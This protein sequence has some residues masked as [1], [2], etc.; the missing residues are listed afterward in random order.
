MGFEYE[1]Y[2]RKGTLPHIWCPGCGHGIVMKSLLRAIDGLKLDKNDIAVVSGIGCASRLPGYLDMNTLHTTHGRALAFATGIKL[3]NPK[4]KVIVVSGDGDAAAIG[5]NHF[6]HAARR[7][8]EI[9]LLVFNNSIYGMTGGQ[10][11]P[12][13]PLGAIAT[14]MPYG[15][16]D[17]PFDIVKLAEGA[18][19]TFVARTTS[20]HTA[21]TEQLI[22]QAIMHKGFS[23]I[24]IID[25]CPVQFGRRNKPKEAPDMMQVQ[26]DNAIPI[27][28]AQK[29][30]PE[31]IAGKIITGVF[32]KKDLPSYV[33]TYYNTIIPKAQAK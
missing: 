21:Q 26:K 17:P 23:V 4:L 30:K 27:Q 5:G 22:K 8:I 19:A 3:A 16:I 12:T 29:K 33:E 2:I 20:Y 18:G 9:T 15:N 11:A 14:T 7:N 31:E 24:D 28:L 25:A 6:I 32:V 1:K 10:V 13:T